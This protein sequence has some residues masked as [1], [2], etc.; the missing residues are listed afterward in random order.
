[1]QRLPY[2]LTLMPEY[3]NS[4]GFNI[5]TH[6]WT[7]GVE[8]KFYLFFPA[9]VFLLIRTI[10]KDAWRFAVTAVTTAV[11]MMQGSFTA[12][13][14]GAILAG[15]MLAQLLEWPRAYAAI[16]TLTRVPLVVPMGFVVA[17]FALLLYVEVLPAVTLVATYLVAYLILHDSMLRRGLCYA[18]LIYLGQRILR[19]LSA[20]RAGDPLRLYD[21][22]QHHAARRLADGGDDAGIDH[23]GGRIALPRRRGAGRRTRTA[24]QQPAAPRRQARLA[25]VRSAVRSGHQA[26]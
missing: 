11:L 20:A 18:P 23:P 16:A 26:A 12:N 6:A 24:D 22:R 7:V 19:C 2:Y 10:H 8:M 25:G 15:A 13:A 17:L 5:F 4:T 9:I 3:S 21:V 1:M 14:Y